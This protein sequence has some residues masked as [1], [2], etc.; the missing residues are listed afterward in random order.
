MTCGGVT[1]GKLY[2]DVVELLVLEV[3]PKALLLICRMSPWAALKSVI[4]SAVEA[5]YAGAVEN[6]KVSA[7]FAPVRISTPSLPS[8]T[9]FALLPMIVL[10]RALPVQLIAFFHLRVRDD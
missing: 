7:P 10:F 1:E 8:R 2:I 3:I 4:R 6:M 5:P 9:L